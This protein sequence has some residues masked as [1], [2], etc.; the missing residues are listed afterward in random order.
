MMSVQL[1]RRKF[2][3]SCGRAGVRRE[4]REPWVATLQH[5]SQHLYR[6]WGR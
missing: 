1:K 3:S 4:C 5:L 6:L 2:Q